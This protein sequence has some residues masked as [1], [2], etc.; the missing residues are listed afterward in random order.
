MK[1]NKLPNPNRPIVY[2]IDAKGKPL[3]RIASEIALIIQGKLLPNYAPEKLSNVVV[4]VKNSKEITISGKKMKDKKYH[5]YSGYPGGIKS[6]Q[7]GELFKASPEKFLLKVVR[8]MLPKN[9]LRPKML[10]KIQF[11]KSND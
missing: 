11:K 2:R 10:K 8:N 9:K 5:R 1:K 3:G 6:K 4:V 7:M